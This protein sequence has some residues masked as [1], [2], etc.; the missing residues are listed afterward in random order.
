MGVKDNL[1][2]D[3]LLNYVDLNVSLE[4]KISDLSLGMKQ[5][6]NI[7][8]ALSHNPDILLLDEPFNGL[9][10]SGISK[11]KNIIKNFKKADKVVI[12]SSHSFRE[13][14]DVIDSVIVLDNGK[15]ISADDI[16]FFSSKNI[17]NIEEY[18]EMVKRGTCND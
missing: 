9:D 17:N 10:R 1:N 14:D 7:A 13:L 18:F 6:L 3:K 2:I 8:I 15:V 4:T 16:S 5:K 11:L 12:I